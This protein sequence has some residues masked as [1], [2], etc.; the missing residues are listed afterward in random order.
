[1]QTAKK[2]RKF[3]IRNC[4]VNLICFSVSK[5]VC[6]SV[7]ICFG[8][9]L[10]LCVWVRSIFV[11]LKSQSVEVQTC[12]ISIKFTILAASMHRQRPVT[13]LPFV[14]FH[15]FYVRSIF[16]F[17]RFL[18]PFFALAFQ[19]PYVCAVFV[20]VG[21]LLT[22]WNLMLAIFGIIFRLE[23]EMEMLS[24]HTHI[25]ESTRNNV[26]VENGWRSP[27]CLPHHAAK[28]L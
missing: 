18:V 2:L 4:N 27:T 12:V 8:C 23:C 11:F 21:M 20:V 22:K 3:L 24:T 5:C 10:V 7:W 26:C 1:M 19:Q 6:W 28:L 25:Q 13:L 14:Y 17:R 9:V 15:F 16:F